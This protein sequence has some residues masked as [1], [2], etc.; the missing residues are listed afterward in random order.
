MKVKMFTVDSVF[1]NSDID[2]LS[3]EL[4]NAFTLSHEHDF[5][6]VSLGIV[7]D[8][9]CQLFVD[10][11]ISHGDVDRYS[12]LQFDDVLLEHFDLSL[13]ILQLS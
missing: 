9:L 4:V 2:S 1:V 6:L 12:L 11:V 10:Q 3:S 8:V 5:E 13:S 7:V